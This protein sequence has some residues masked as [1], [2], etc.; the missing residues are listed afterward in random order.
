MADE[1]VSWVQFVVHQ[2][3]L[4]TNLVQ[5]SGTLVLNQ[6]EQTLEASVLCS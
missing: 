1:Q 3:Y 6:V 2:E 5:N 4:D